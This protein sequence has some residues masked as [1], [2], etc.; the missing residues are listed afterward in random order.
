MLT[1][2]KLKNY[3]ATKKLHGNKN[4]N[5]AYALTFG[6]I[7]GILSRPSR[8][9]LADYKEKL[10]YTCETEILLTDRFVALYVG[11]IS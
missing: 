3:L 8:P 4:R 6:I 1:I 11:I 5:L 7:T 2:H 10:F 9:F